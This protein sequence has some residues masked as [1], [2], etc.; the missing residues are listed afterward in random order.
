VYAA[1]GAF[2][3]G[4][5]NPDDSEGETHAERLVRFRDS[6]RRAAAAIEKAA[7]KPKKRRKEAAPFL[8][9]QPAKGRSARRA[10][11]RA[12]AAGLQ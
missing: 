8:A 4:Y 3:E 11:E 1:K 5:L 2:P 9:S 12:T 6:K 7:M 10:A